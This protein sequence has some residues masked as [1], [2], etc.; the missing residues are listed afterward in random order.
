MGARRRASISRRFKTPTSFSSK[1]L[2][3]RLTPLKPFRTGLSAVSGCHNNVTAIGPLGNSQGSSSSLFSSSRSSTQ[4]GPGR[5]KRDL[6]AE[7]DHV[8][9]DAVLFRGF[10]KNLAAALSRIGTQQSGH[11]NERPR[12]DREHWRTTRREVE[13][14][15]SQPELVK[16]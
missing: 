14:T 13:K 15:K 16:Q 11:P 2:L 3:I 1:S 5:D 8:H 4:N 10:G 7:I 12:E 9:I 6:V